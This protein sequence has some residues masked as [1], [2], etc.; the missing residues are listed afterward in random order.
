MN[1]KQFEIIQEGRFKEKKLLNDEEIE[2]A[3]KILNNL[4]GILVVRATPILEFCLEAI[5]FSKIKNR[6]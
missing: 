5:Q 6:D 2:V 3:N 4:E 1:I